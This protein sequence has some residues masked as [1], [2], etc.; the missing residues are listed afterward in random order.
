MNKIPRST[1]KQVQAGLV[2]IIPPALTHWCIATHGMPDL[3]SVGLVIAMYILTGFGI[4]IGFHRYFVHHSFEILHIWF[5]YVL[6]IL[7]LMA[8][9]GLLSE[10]ITAHREHHLHADKVGDPHS[11]LRYGTGFVNILKGFVFAHVGWFFIEP[12]TPTPTSLKSDPIVR[13]ID[14]LFLPA[15]AVGLLLPGCIGALIRGSLDG[16]LVDVI[17]GGFARMTLVHHTTWSVNSICHLWGTRVFK[18]RDESTNNLFVALFGLGEGNHNCHH[19]F[20]RSARHGLLPGQPD[21]SYRVLQGL[22]KMGVV[23]NIIVPSNDE[24]AKKLAA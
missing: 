21:L 19:A 13:R 15:V 23:A 20:P 17:W 14:R 4:T 24:I 6:G 9:E 11:P 8:L 18:T 1:S 5:I 7:G 12:I 2:I 22:E 16:F 3:I 10:W